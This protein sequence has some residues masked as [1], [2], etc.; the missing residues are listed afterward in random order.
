M[1]NNIFNVND[2][3]KLPEAV[4]KD[5]YGTIIS[6]YVDRDGIQYKVRYFWESKP[7]EVYFYEQE[8]KGESNA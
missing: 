2:K 3:I 4:H 1:I 5:L 6:I 8:L 7:Q